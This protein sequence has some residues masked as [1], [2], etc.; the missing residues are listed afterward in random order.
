MSTI[1]TGLYT[2]PS[3]ASSAVRTLEARGIPTADISV[4]A[5]E[6]TRREAFGIE[7]KS[8]AAEGGAVGAGLGGAMGALIAG[9]TMVGALATG[10]VG[11][12]AAGPL[13][14]ALAGAGAGAAA[15][16]AVGTLVGLAIP[17]N[18]I[19]FYDDA[20][21]KGSVLVGVTCEDDNRRD[22]VNEIFKTSGATKISHA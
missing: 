8:K 10:G 11:L 12:L 5:A 9:F 13:V 19:K 2:S 1:L 6:G 7:G 14:A 18:E 3:A 20:L 4:V 17:Q 15:G 22:L 21:R 16:G